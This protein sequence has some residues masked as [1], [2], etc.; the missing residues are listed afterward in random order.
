[1]PNFRRDGPAAAA[2]FE[3]IWG[4]PNCLGAISAALLESEHLDQFIR[5][6]D[7]KRYPAGQHLAMMVDAKLHMTYCA[8]LAGVLG[9]D[10]FEM[11]MEVCNMAQAFQAPPLPIPPPRAPKGSKVKLPY[12]FVGD[13]RLGART[14]LRVATEG[15][16]EANK[17]I[18]RAMTPANIA[19]HMILSRFG[20]LKLKHPIVL[21][22]ECMLITIPVLHNYFM[23]MNPAY[24]DLKRL[25]R[26][27]KAA[28]ES[29]SVPLPKAQRFTPV[30]AH[31]AMLRMRMDDNSFQTVIDQT[32]LSPLLWAE[33]LWF[34][35]T[36]RFEKDMQIAMSV[37]IN[38]LQMDLMGYSQ[39]V[40]QLLSRRILH[41]KYPS[42]HILI[43]SSLSTLPSG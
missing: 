27:Y 12:T 37:G 13:H 42:L 11:I 26:E 30:I 39:K 2:E 21:H 33:I 5:L 40:S 10:A 36:G 43:F 17:E 25:L 16:D 9:E 31:D 18:E 34:I 1:M 38:E 29:D 3:A 35:G 23:R 8:I 6:S 28:P 15:N 19:L 22:N 32:G 24:G 7:G 14:W 20:V 4:V 41:L